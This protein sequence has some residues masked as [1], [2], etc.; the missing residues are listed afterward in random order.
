MIEVWDYQIDD[1]D[2]CITS[3]NVFMKTYINKLSEGEVVGCFVFDT[4]EHIKILKYD[5]EF[6][7]DSDISYSMVRQIVAMQCKLNF[8]KV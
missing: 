4:G 3:L 5:D 2:E 7:V 8:L 6:V 1:K